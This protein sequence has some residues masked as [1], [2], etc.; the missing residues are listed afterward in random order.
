VP[1]TTGALPHGYGSLGVSA[2]GARAARGRPCAPR[3]RREQRPRQPRPPPG[4]SPRARPVTVATSQRDGPDRINA[5][6]RRFPPRRRHC[7]PATSRDTRDTRDT[8]GAGTRKTPGSSHDRRDRSD[9]QDPRDRQPGQQAACR[10]ALTPKEP[11][12]SYIAGNSPIRVC[13][14]PMSRRPQMPVDLMNSP[15]GVFR[16]GTGRK[17]P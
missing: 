7:P 4:T 13:R 12:P 10:A 9:R 6:L 11:H 2:A 17:G 16:T 14:Y 15:V 3:P 5:T 8:R 1:V